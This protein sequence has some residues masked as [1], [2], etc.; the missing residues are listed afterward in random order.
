MV[1]QDDGSAMKRAAE[2]LLMLSERAKG[3]TQEQPAHRAGMSVRAVREY[4]R[5]AKLPSQLK[6][7]RTYRSRPNPFA[8][9]WLWMTTLLGDDPALQGQ[10]LFEL[11]CDRHPGRYQEGQLRTLQPHIATWRAPSLPQ[12]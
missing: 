10:T 9:D 11:L 2:V 4:E 6:Q 1:L 8:D 12:P 3:R 5:H 7:P